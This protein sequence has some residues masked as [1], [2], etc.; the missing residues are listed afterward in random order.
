M[1]GTFAPEWFGYETKDGR[2]RWVRMESVAVISENRWMQDNGA[3]SRW[4]K[5]IGHDGTVLANVPLPVN[6]V[7]DRFFGVVRE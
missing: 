2:Q 3:Y 6:E 1:R 7:A 5:L 4:T